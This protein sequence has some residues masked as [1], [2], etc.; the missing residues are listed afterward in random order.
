MM[1]TTPKL[2]NNKR[3]RPMTDKN[4]AG[5]SDSMLELCEDDPERDGD[6]GY[7]VLPWPKHQVLV[8]AWFVLGFVALV[9]FTLG[10]AFS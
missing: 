9:S 4:K 3:K 10:A 5:F 2:K 7:W 8:A 6:T 1:A